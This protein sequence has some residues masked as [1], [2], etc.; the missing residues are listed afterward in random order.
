LEYDELDDNEK[1]KVSVSPVTKRKPTKSSFKIPKKN[2]RKR[3]KSQDG[4]CWV[5]SKKLKTQPHQKTPNPYNDQQV[6]VTSTGNRKATMSVD[7]VDKGPEY[8]RP[9]HF[10]VKLVPEPVSTQIQEFSRQKALILH[11][12]R[13]QVILQCGKGRCR[14]FHLMKN[15]LMI[16]S[17]CRSVG[18]AMTVA[19]KEK[20]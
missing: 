2:E 5:V 13:L 1:L 10:L 17:V 19:K 16:L 20:V 18:P 15:L 11:Q 7:T 9:T 3:E 8:V 14:K 12:Q 6:D 4:S